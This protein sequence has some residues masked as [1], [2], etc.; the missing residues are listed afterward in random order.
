[1]SREEQRREIAR[2]RA[3]ADLARLRFSNAV[4]DALDRIAPDRLRRDAV[5]F[6]ADQVEDAWRELV[7]RFPYWPLALGAL[8][9]GVAAMIA[10]QPARTAARHAVRLIELVWATR[11]FWS[12]TN[13]GE[14]SRT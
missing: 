14:G 13:D 9:A 6:A 1:M 12:R 2:A 8:G 4:D 7:R 5:E 3:R 11:Q 10:W